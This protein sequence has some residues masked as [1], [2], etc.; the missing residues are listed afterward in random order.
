[1]T[2]EYS[3]TISFLPGN[4][5]G[6]FAPRSEFGTGPGPAGVAIADLNGDGTPDVAVASAG[7]S[8][9]HVGTVT[10]LLNTEAI[11]GVPRDFP[12]APV[13]FRMLAP[14]PS[15]SRG[16][17][18]FQFVLTARC[19]VEADVIDATGRR[20]RRLSASQEFPAGEHELVWDGRNQQGRSV[21][22]GVYLVRIRVG[23]D[24]AVRRFALL[25]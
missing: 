6:A 23:Q 24:V 20:V 3:S 7:I 22:S 4:G 9:A 17:T 16:A 2:N 13:L 10:V 12:A 15:P 1:V 21:P 14:R 5:S 11:V 18:H 25:R 19:A 8:P